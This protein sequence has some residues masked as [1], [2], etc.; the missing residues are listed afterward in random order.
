M[1]KARVVAAAFVVGLLAALT[2]TGQTDPVPASGV[3]EITVPAKTR[4]AA[5]PGGYQPVTPG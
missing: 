1:L 5:T 3:S 2:A 4:A